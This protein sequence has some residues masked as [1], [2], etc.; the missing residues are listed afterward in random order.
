M[1]Q[2]HKDM[3]KGAAME[4]ALG[5]SKSSSSEPVWGLMTVLIYFC[6]FSLLS[7]FTVNW[8][9][10]TFNLGGFIDFRFMGLFIVFFFG[11]MIIFLAIKKKFLRKSTRK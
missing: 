7:F 10:E 11:Y 5:S 2:K 8:F 6:W 4:K 3:L 1:K 9:Y